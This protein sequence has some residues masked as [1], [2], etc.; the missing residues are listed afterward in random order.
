MLLPNALHPT[1]PS[2]IPWWWWWGRKEVVIVLLLLLCYEGE[3]GAV[4]A[5]E[6]GGGSLRT[7]PWLE[8]PNR[9]RNR[10]RNLRFASVP[11]HDLPDSQPNTQHLV[12]VAVVVVVVVV[13][14]AI[15]ACIS[16]D[17]L[18]SAGCP[19]THSR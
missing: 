12:A 2:N 14:A 16:Y 17:L 6:G 8:R 5:K 15:C 13:A 4:E 7:L 9:L 3:G 1:P 19:H 10:W 11:V 18:C